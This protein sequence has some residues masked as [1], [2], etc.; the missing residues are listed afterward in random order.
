[1]ELVSSF[2]MFLAKSS[3]ICSCIVHSEEALVEGRLRFSIE[4]RSVIDVDSSGVEWW[5]G[6]SF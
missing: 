1:M 6:E 4:S 2:V 3:T 5:E